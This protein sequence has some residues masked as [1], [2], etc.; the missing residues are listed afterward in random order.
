M[1]KI[2]LFVPFLG[3][4][5]SCNN[6]Q[7]GKENQDKKDT[8]TAVLVSDTTLNNLRLCTELPMITSDTSRKGVKK[9]GG[10]KYLLWPKT[11]RVLNIAF[12]DGDP[13]IQ[14]KVQ[15]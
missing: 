9:A 14:E 4:L 1:L 3:L 11:T 2:F 15:N 12:L 8:T 7:N 6:S 5:F 10:L 13:A